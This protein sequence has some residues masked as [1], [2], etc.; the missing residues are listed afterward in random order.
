MVVDL[1][2]SYMPFLARNVMQTLLSF[3]KYQLVD[4]VRETQSQTKLLEE[5]LKIDI[6]KAEKKREEGREDH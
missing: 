4:V 6:W 3:W 1:V 5:T 2:R